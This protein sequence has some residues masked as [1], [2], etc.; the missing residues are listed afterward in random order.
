[1]LRT[2][3]PVLEANIIAS[4]GSC[5]LPP[6]DSQLSAPRWWKG[7][8]RCLRPLTCSSSSSSSRH[9]H[10]NRD[11]LLQL[12]TSD[13]HGPSLVHVI[14]CVVRYSTKESG[15]EREL[16]GVWYG[17][18][19]LVTAYL[20]LKIIPSLTRRGALEQIVAIVDFVTVRLLIEN[21]IF[22]WL[23]KSQPTPGRYINSKRSLLYWTLCHCLCVAFVFCWP[24]QVSP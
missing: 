24:G 14:P 12:S 1:M 11:S 8:S 13:C 15:T 3:F 10:C 18:V 5:E 22:Q 4:K 6:F 17:T 2:W 21:N 16:H 20:S 23:P 7:K 19:L 9:C